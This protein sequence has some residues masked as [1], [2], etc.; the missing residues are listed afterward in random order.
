M[1]K[2]QAKAAAKEAYKAFR[3][4][5]V[6]RNLIG[7]KSNRVAG[8]FVDSEELGS[9]TNAIVLRIIFRDSKNIS[10]DTEMIESL[11]E[12]GNFE[13]D[14]INVVEFDGDNDERMHEAFIDFNYL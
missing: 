11:I 4:E 5:I 10:W 8:Y 14:N 1:N 12:E 6:Y 7:K 2:Q 3:D 9:D 13:Q